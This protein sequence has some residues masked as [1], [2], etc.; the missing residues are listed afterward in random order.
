MSDCIRMTA[1]AALLM[2]M[3]VMGKQTLAFDWTDEDC[4]RWNGS[5]QRECLQAKNDLANSDCSKWMRGEKEWTKCQ[6][7]HEEAELLRRLQRRPPPVVVDDH[8]PT[9]HGQR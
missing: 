4:S 3:L 6:R 2:G 1:A 7:L 8:K 5:Q 9:V